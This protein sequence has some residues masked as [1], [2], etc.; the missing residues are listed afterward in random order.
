MNVRYRIDFEAVD[1]GCLIHNGT[2]YLDVPEGA[3]PADA[4]DDEI[5]K[6]V[7]QDFDSCYYDFRVLN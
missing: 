4:A 3:D 7:P 1:R 2:L 6:L 5:R